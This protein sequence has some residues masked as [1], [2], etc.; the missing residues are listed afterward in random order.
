MLHAPNLRQ[1]RGMLALET[2]DGS[3]GLALDG[4]G[5]LDGAR[6]IRHAL[7]GAV[8][9]SGKVGLDPLE[10]TNA[11]L[12]L[13]GPGCSPAGRAYAHHAPVADAG[14]FGGHIQHA[15]NDGGRKGGVKAIDNVHMAQNRGEHGGVPLANLKALHQAVPRRA[16]SG[17]GRRH[18]AVEQQ[19]LTGGVIH[20]KGER[21]SARE[22][23]AAH[24]DQRLEVRREQLL[25]QPLQLHRGLDDVTQAGG[26]GL[27]MVAHHACGEG[28]GIAQARVDLAKTGELGA[29]VGELL[30]RLGLLVA[31]VGQ[32]AHGHIHG[33]LGL[34]PGVSRLIELRQELVGAATFAPLTARFR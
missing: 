1:Q 9:E 21:G 18:I 28:R 19:R 10:L 33:R 22:G 5:L 15:R 11:A 2:R 26:D 29:H 13:K 32:G 4:P 31:Q 7:H 24:A 30:A 6:R 12:A 34:N 23:V 16:G 3:R 14:A 20:P 25:D 17:N 27:G 8:E